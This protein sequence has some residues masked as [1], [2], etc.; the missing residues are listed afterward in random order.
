MEGFIIF[1]LVIVI[2]VLAFGN[3]KINRRLRYL[4]DRMFEMNH[5]INGLQM[6]SDEII[7]H[8]EKIK[9][10]AEKEQA[11]PF[12]YDEKQKEEVT[13]KE[14]TKEIKKDPEQITPEIETIDKKEHTNEEPEYV[15]Q[16]T[17][18][19]KHTLYEKIESEI[20]DNEKESVETQEIEEADEKEKAH[21]IDTPKIKAGISGW[22]DNFLEKNPDLEKFI[23]ENLINKIGI[24]ILV[25]GI[26]FLVKWAIDNDY[27]NEA[28]RVGVGFLSGGILIGIAH[29]LRINFKAFSSVLIGGGLAV[30]YFTIAI[31][32]HEY[33]IFNQTIAFVLM[34]LITGFA[35]LLS[36]AYNRMELAILA[37]L[38]GFAT[39][40]LVSTGEGNYIILFTYI[41]ILNT[42]MLV[43]AYFKRWHPINVIAY[44]A[45]VILFGGWLTR[46]FVIMKNVPHTGALFFA[47]V[48]FLIFFFMNIINN[49]RRGDK[50]RVGVI[51]ILL[52]NTFLYYAAGMIILDDFIP[53]SKGIFTA[54]L[55]IFN[56]G[57]AY[58]FY[59]QKSID[60]NLV[61][62]LIGL[63]LT[64]VSLIA[65][66]QL[67]GNYI[68]V[69]WAAESVLLLWLSLQSGIKVIRFASVL[70]TALMI[71]SLIIDWEA[72]YFSYKSE[73]EHSRIIFNK[74]FLT[75]L[76]S[77]VALFASGIIAGKFSETKIVYINKH[78]FGKIILITGF[79][80]LYFTGRFELIFQADQYVE[81]R[82][83]S[84]TMISVYNYAFA[85]AV[86]IWAQISKP[87]KQAYIRIAIGIWA[88][89]I[90]LVYYHIV[91]GSLR[92]NIF[93]NENVELSHF[94]F[95]FVAIILLV[96]IS[97]ISLQAVYQFFYPKITKFN[98]SLWIFI[99]LWVFI[100][101]AELDNIIVIT[102]FK[103]DVS[104]YYWIKQSHRI[105]FPILWGVCSFILM[106]IG[107]KKEIRQLRIISLS[108]FMLTVVKLFALDVWEMSEAGRIAAF[109]LLGVFLLIV[110]FLYQKLKQLIIDEDS[111]KNLQ[112]E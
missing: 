4:K 111:N 67:K 53:G 37:I 52:S 61:Y 66:V 2:I 9:Y 90:Y 81:L 60:R 38:G 36:I 39:P 7:N 73:L 45:T 64:F 104:V 100:L 77:S 10:K 105:G 55:A 22:I 23:G 94:M 86:L 59:R 32:F 75:G 72:L 43:L 85:L 11:E 57:F 78:I 93:N 13:D 8:L 27:I 62:F 14:K 102:F 1:L 103:E 71:V 96:I 56:F 69:F 110:S 54:I 87:T 41:T 5:R 46:E 109:V 49:L 29:R 51:I 19:E 44:V 31:A 58:V 80:V 21:T 74:G 20:P 17:T 68:T 98:Y 15:W 25:L 79:V 108:L 47:T 84:I 107:M 101:S 26:S 63:V 82:N 34:V 88:A 106:L 3:A 16:K 95:H 6:H 70:V 24:A 33:Q 35:I 97:I 112:N 83:F 40:F 28:G 42:G 99:F 91:Y 89:L 65:P 50:F 30:L 12:V 76:F 48:F 18:N 92:N